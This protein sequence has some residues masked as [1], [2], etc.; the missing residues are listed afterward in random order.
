[1]FSIVLTFIVVLA[2]EDTR[3]VELLAISLNLRVLQQ[4]DDLS[5][6]VNDNGLGTSHTSATARHIFNGNLDE[7]VVTD[8]LSSNS[9]TI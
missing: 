3:I 4:F 9:R 1:M 8:F 7:G 2:P 6:D 5:V